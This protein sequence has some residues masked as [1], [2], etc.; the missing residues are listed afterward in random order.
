[1]RKRESNSAKK[2]YFTTVTILES[3]SDAIFILDKDGRI[4]YANKGALNIL[5][6][7]INDLIGRFIDEIIIDDYDLK[8]NIPIQKN[9]D[10]SKNYKLLEKFNNGI[11]GNIETAI[12]YNGHI[13]P[14]ILSFSVI[15]SGSDKLEYIAVTAK[16]ISH[17]KVIEKEQKQQQA[18]SISKDRL[19]ILGEL[20]AG[21]VHELSQP[22][23][24]LLFKVEEMGACI[25]NNKEQ[26]K[27]IKEMLDLINKMSDKIQRIRTYVNQTEGAT[28]VLVNLNEVI[29]K[30]AALVSKDLNNH[31]IELTINKEKQLPYILA[32]PLIMEQVFVSLLTNSQEAFRVI[33]ERGKPPRSGGVKSINIVTKT[34]ENKWIE[35]SIEDNAG[36]IDKQIRGKIFDPFF[37]TKN[38]ETNLGIGLSISKNVIS[39]LGGDIKVTVNNG[40]GTRFVIRIPIMQNKEQIQLNNFI[41]M[42][43]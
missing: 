10:R 28:I 2:D 14:V 38:P 4:K 13:T 19:K 27:K 32:N 30:A 8:E 33:E 42:L 9:E 36:G 20:S 25:I 16:D 37:T 21:L 34:S 43:Q 22:L 40:T 35:I 17:W 24:A 6:I 12:I 3:I 7:D 1:M 26:V 5:R 18:L 15:N 23:S 41:E 39:S 29:S 31:N 11:F